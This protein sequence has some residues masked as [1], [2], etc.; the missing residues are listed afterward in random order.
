MQC[1][2]RIAPF[3]LIGLASLPAH[4]NRRIAAGLALL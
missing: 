4:A 3:G 2:P 1:I